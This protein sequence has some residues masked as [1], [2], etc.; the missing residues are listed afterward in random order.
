M[1]I[2]SNL[3]TPGDAPAVSRETVALP[4]A[5]Q[6]NQTRRFLRSS[7]LFLLVGFL[8]YV[9]IYI[10]ADQLVYNYAKRNRFFAV[11]TAAVAQYDYVILG[12]SHAAAFDYE[13]MTPRLEQMTNSKIINL[14][15]VGSG[16][17]V[18]RLLLDYF[19]T[20]HRTK[21]IVYVVDSF[22]FYSQ[23]WNE[24]RLNDTRL[25]VRAPFDPVLIQTLSSSPAGRSVLP[26]YVLGFSKINNPDR[27][28]PDINDDERT[29]FNSTYR[30]VKQI[31][32]QRLDYLYP[33]EIDEATFQRYLGQFEDLVRYLQ[34][35]NIRLIVIK[36]PIPTR[37]Y[38][39]LPNEPQFDER[40]QAILTRYGIEYHDFSL[41]GNDEKFYFNTDHLNKTGVLNFF[42]NYLKG[43]LMQ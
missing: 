20:S 23:Q 4:T 30:P 10:A 33:K 15:E 43:V 31:D 41:V 9:V 35:H 32:Q 16:I 13:D 25:F 37:I 34:A 2:K 29:K 28:A 38:Q 40:L 39:M 42:D 24:D 21:S 12:A 17:F 5:H 7:L 22:A 3:D 36:P 1:S 27:F 26:D 6:E 14:S 18:N 8:I 19:L 11:K